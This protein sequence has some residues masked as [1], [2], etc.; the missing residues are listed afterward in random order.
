MVCLGTD[1]TGGCVPSLAPAASY[2]VTWWPVTDAGP[3]FRFRATELCVLVAASPVGVSGRATVAGAKSPPPTAKFPAWSKA[4][5]LTVVRAVI[6]I[7]PVY[8][9]AVSDGR[10]PLITGEPSVVKN[11]WPLLLTVTEPASVTP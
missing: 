4:A 2:T 10:S 7:G 6:G 3:A 8:S 1:V 9:F 5:T 11:T